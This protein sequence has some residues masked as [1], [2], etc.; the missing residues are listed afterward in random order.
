MAPWFDR[1]GG[2]TQYIK[3]HENGEAYSINELI[4]EGYIREVSVR[5]GGLKNE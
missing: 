2:G 5:K 3:Y 4:D 1:P